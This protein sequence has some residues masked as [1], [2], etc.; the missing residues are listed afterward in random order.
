MGEGGVTPSFIGEDWLFNDG[1]SFTETPPVELADAAQLESPRAWDRFLCV[2]LQAK[3]GDF[4]H[5]TVLSE[6]LLE[7]QAHPLFLATMYLG[8][9]I[10]GPAEQQALVRWLG[11]E[12]FT[13]AAAAIVLT[14]E[15]ALVEALLER[16]RGAGTEIRETMEGTVSQLL[17][18]EPDCFYE[19]DLD[20]DAYDAAVRAE[21]AALRARHGADFRVVFGAPLRPRTLIAKL[22]Q[23]SKL[24]REPLDENCALVGSVA[25]QLETFTGLSSKELVVTDGSGNEIVDRA[26]LMRIIEAAE[27]WDAKHRP[28]SGRRMFFGHAVDVDRSP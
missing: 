25:L 5:V 3:R 15:L 28:R 14:G 9:A 27:T 21:V 10:G 12:W 20:D 17:E 22:T 2:F 16:R 18:P 6:L 13:Q 1:W 11:T 23:L 26:R 7:E 8:A 19:T 4:A 24:D